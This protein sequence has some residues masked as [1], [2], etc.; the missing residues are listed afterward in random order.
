MVVAGLVLGLTAVIHDAVVDPHDVRGRVVRE[1]TQGDPRTVSA[2]IVDA[3]AADA[4]SGV[5]YAVLIVV[6]AT[7]PFFFLGGE[8]GA[9]LPPIVLSYLLA[10][11]ASMLVALTVTPV[12]SLLLLADAPASSVT[13]PDGSSGCDEA[14]T[15]R[16]RG[17][18]RGRVPR[19][20]SPPSIAAIGLLAVPFLDA[21]CGRRSR[22]ETCLS[23]SRPRPARRFPR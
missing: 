20:W 17:S 3:T 16:L 2:T 19:S 13:G 8:S 14:T 15:E 6:A 23:T 12:L 11:V 22:S 7:V 10:V 1:S 4:P 21:S 9:F 5:L 18:S